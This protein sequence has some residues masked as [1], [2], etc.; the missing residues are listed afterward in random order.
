M[1]ILRNAFTVKWPSEE[2]KI[3]QHL[4]VLHIYTI[5]FVEEFSYSAY[6]QLSPFEGLKP[7]FLLLLLYVQIESHQLRKDILWLKNINE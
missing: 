4:Y 7:N 2:G 5:W 1:Y 6:Q 3:K